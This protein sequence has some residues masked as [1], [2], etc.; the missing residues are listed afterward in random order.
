MTEK[1]RLIST[2]RGEVKEIFNKTDALYH[3][4]LAMEEYDEYKAMVYGQDTKNKR[5]LDALAMSLHEIIMEQYT[6]VDDLLDR[7]PQW[8]E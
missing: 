8:E 5:T 4:L 7:I 2:F 3:I 6:Y 1:E